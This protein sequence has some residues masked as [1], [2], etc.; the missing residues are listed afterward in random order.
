MGKKYGEDILKVIIF[1]YKF[2]KENIMSDLII[3]YM[4]Y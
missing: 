1:V 2:I 4:T 3:Y